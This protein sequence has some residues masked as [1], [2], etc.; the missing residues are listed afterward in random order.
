MRMLELLLLIAFASMFHLASLMFK[1]WRDS[2][3]IALM[4]QYHLTTS[5]QIFIQ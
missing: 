4:I 3:K 2:K 5:R 1:D